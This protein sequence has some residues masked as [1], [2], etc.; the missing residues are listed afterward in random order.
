MEDFN[1][2]IARDGPFDCAQGAWVESRI[3]EPG[4][5]LGSVSLSNRP[6][7]SF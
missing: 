1:A 5:S 6:C 2:E 4:P 3:G 7:L